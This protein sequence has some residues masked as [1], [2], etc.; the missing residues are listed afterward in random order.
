VH[1][2]GVHGTNGNNGLHTNNGLHA[3]NGLHTN[4][5][6]HGTAV[7]HPGNGQMHSTNGNGHQ[8][9]NGVPRTA[10]GTHA[11]GHNH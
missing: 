8:G 3:N 11:P 10:D 9:G 2:N 4:N 5:G 7:L 6:T 1:G